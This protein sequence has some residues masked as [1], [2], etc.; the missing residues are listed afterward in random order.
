M[1]YLQMTEKNIN[2]VLDQF[3]LVILD[4]YADWCVP[5]KSFAPTF[6]KVSKNYPEVA[7]GKVNTEKEHL[8]TEDFS[9]R[10]IP[11][12]VVLKQKTIILEK[13]GA[14][15][16]HSLIDLVEAALKVDITKLESDDEL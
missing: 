6:A 14:M 2:E 5:C 16:E 3:D 13:S 10:S 1:N 12:I 4:F 9:I 11:T 8:L 7:F 15:F